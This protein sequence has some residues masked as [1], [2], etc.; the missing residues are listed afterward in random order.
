M[1]MTIGEASA[2]ARLLHVLARDDRAQSRPPSVEQLTE[3]L[4]LLNARAAKPLQPRTHPVACPDCDWTVAPTWSDANAAWLVRRHQTSKT[5]CGGTTP[6]T[7]QDPS[8]ATTGCQRRPAKQ[9]GDGL[10]MTC[11]HAA[12]EDHESPL[13]LT[14]RGRWV[15]APGGIRVWQEAVPA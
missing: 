3:D 6:P 15:K 9:W 8:C 2:V 5:G 7:R 12:T 14:G 11:H 13:D 1:S 10:C 4:A